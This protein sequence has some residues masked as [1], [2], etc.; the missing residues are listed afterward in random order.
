MELSPL[1][2][3]YQL[4]CLI[5]WA[6]LLLPTTSFFFLLMS[7][8]K[9][10]PA[11][12]GWAISK[13]AGFFGFAWLVAALP[14]MGVY[15][16]SD[17]VIWG[18]YAAV[19]VISIVGL[20]SKYGFA[21]QALKRGIAKII[22]PES[23]FL[24]VYLIFVFFWS[25][26]AQLGGGEKVMNYTFLNFFIQNNAFPPEDPWAAGV[27][28][29]YYYLGSFAH[30]VF[31]RV[32]N[33]PSSVGYGLGVSTNAGLLAVACY[34]IFRLARV[35]ARGAFGASIVCLLVGNAQTLITFVEKGFVVNPDLFWAS[36]R[37]FDHSH[38]SEFPLWTYLFADLH[39]HNIGLPLGVA[40]I[41][42]F[43]G[44]LE[45]QSRRQAALWGVFFGFVAG[46]LPVTNTWDVFCV[47]AI[48]GAAFFLRP[49]S[50]LRN[51]IPLV[52]AA[53][54]ATLTSL[55]YWPSI[56]GAKPVNIGVLHSEWVT[57]SQVFRFVGLPLLII[58]LSSIPLCRGMPRMWLKVVVTVVGVPLIAATLHHYLSSKFD[59]AL[60]LP[61]LAPALL[62]FG[63]VFVPQAPLAARI[64][65][66]AAAMVIFGIEFF[67]VFD[68]T[69]TL[70]KMYLHVSVLL[71]IVALI[72]CGTVAVK[73][74]RWVVGLNR[75]IIAA[76]LVSGAVLVC[77]NKP[78]I[79]RR[80]S[81][82][83]LD[84]VMPL[85]LSERDMGR[86]LQWMGNNITGSPRILDSW[87]AGGLGR[88]TM[89]LGFPNFAHWEAHT[90]KRGVPHEELLKRRD[91]I[92]EF[93][94]SATPERAY[95]ILL[96]NK[97]DYFV[98]SETERRTYPDAALAVGG[99]KF[100]ARP[101]LF[102]KI[103]QEGEAAL[104]APRKP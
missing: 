29:Q 94:T 53:I 44:L 101:D 66:L 15:A 86:L 98:V 72:L 24:I 75:A 67:V 14:S 16:L 78:N 46:M 41:A 2:A 70:F 4:F 1:S 55:P 37:V 87:G 104:F 103:R 27:R 21:P 34:A 25:L 40:A 48:C 99:S 22:V 74:V 88:V 42:L 28:M 19:C 96:D 30:A 51:W 100:D 32:G 82:M 11:D 33:I 36:S 77:A 45:E 50:V 81:A 58:A 76:S 93:F 12:I 57:I 13:V 56:F 43:I 83:S 23:L 59:I 64:L 95:Q 7:R 31:H 65:A 26:F 35:S 3:Q 79:I 61:H 49:L 91:L 38:F 54:V 8:I 73:G 102:N 68:R 6:L 47:M 90:V 17:G 69:I 97:I 92:N 18:T 9:G 71:W 20:G 85:L 62:L 80:V 52:V 39:A 89:N 63:V 5:L 10:L 84:A 60:L